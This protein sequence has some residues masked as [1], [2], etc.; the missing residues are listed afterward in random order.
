E[1]FRPD[2]FAG[3]G[4]INYRVLLRDGEGIV[5]NGYGYKIT[6][7]D[8]YANGVNPE[9]DKPVTDIIFPVGLGINYKLNDMFNIE[10][11][12][13]SRFINSDKLDGKVRYKN[14]KYWFVSLGL[15]YKFNNKKFL[16]DILNK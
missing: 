6:A 15:T 7:G 2:A 9:K 3:I 11:E 12:A 8:S 13:S 14:D 10:L 16:S 5:I 1:K 4:F